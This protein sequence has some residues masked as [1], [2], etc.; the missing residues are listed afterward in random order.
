MPWRKPDT[1]ELRDAV[2]RSIPEL[3]AGEIEYLA[4]GW[5]F[6]AFRAGDH[7]L[8]FPKAERGF[9][10]K[11]ADQ[12]S[13]DS[14]RIEAALTPVLSRVLSTPIT[15]PACYERG[16]N[17]APFSVH[18]YLSGEV[19]MYASRKPEAGFGRDL[20]RLIR[21]LRSFSA[22]RALDLGVP[23][24]DGPRL[25]NDR[26]RHYEAVIR[27]AFPLLGCE[28]RAHVERVYEAYL[29]DA[30]CFE[31]EPVLAHTDLAV[32]VLIDPA[33]GSLCGL[34]DFGDAA[35]SSP[36]L[37]FW[38]PVHGFPRLGIG[39]MLPDWIEA[40]GVD[41]RT[42][43][44]MQPELAFL[45]VRYPLLGVLHGL[46]LGDEAFVEESIRE[47]NQLVPRDLKC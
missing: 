22:Q 34:I 35:V 13:R 4:E 44:T 19:V 2:R 16:P 33:R 15:V 26:A 11:L 39:G 9:V 21:E 27:G 8:R 41:E 38:L 18:R 23:L 12:S 17:G 3:A 31:F 32:N 10:W 14:L 25:R 1:A 29:N 28:A 7:V 46:Q 30:R 6:W 47:L 37:D 36:A 42:L 43:A 5:E 45:D 40:A 20:G 24:F